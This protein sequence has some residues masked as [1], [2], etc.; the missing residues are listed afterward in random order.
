LVWSSPL[1][2]GTVSG[3]FKNA[4]DWLQLLGDHEPPYLT[5]KV[6]GLVSTAGGTHASRG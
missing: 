2:H 3:A 5:D 1:N 4:L 6:I